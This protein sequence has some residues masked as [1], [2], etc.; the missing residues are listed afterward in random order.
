MFVAVPNSMINIV[1]DVSP[2]H[3]RIQALTISSTNSTTLLINSYFPVDP[4]T[5]NFDEIELDE[6]LKVI[7][8]V[9]EVNVFQSVLFLGDINCDVKRNN[10]FVQ[11]IQY[12]LSE[13]ISTIDH[14][15]WNDSHGQS[16]LDAGFIHP[17]ENM[18]DHSP[19]Y[20][21][22]NLDTIPVEVAAPDQSPSTT[23]PIWKQAT[24]EEKDNIPSIL[25]RTC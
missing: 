2:G 6:T 21:S 23:K 17:P 5:A 9:L 15:F 16:V 10:R 20:C 14:F 11:I 1:S 25:Q 22:V 24:K 12:V 3:W 13:K 8:G 19:I 18:S 4:R 7:A